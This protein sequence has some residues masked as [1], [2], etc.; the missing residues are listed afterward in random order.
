MLAVVEARVCAK[1]IAVDFAG[2]VTD[3]VNLAQ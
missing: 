3:F 2:Q 1:Q